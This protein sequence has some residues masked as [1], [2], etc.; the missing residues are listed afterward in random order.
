M[1]RLKAIA[2]QPQDRR[3]VELCG[4]GFSFCFSLTPNHTGLRAR[5]IDDNRGATFARQHAPTKLHSLL[6]LGIEVADKP[7]GK[8]VWLDLRTFCKYKPAARLIV[9]CKDRVLCPVAVARALRLEP[10]QRSVKAFWTAG[11]V[12]KQIDPDP[13]VDLCWRADGKPCIPSY[14]VNAAQELSC[15]GA[16][17][18][19][20]L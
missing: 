13:A 18:P 1:H 8:P 6:E 14:N 12:R 11:G 9:G 7:K 16:K 17:F 19:S 20:L 5:R 2:R 15:T 3:S 4:K 10:G